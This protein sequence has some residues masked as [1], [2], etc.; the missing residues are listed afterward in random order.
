MLLGKKRRRKE[1]TRD[2]R[3]NLELI[4]EMCL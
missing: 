3:Y 2:Q 4:D 1:Q